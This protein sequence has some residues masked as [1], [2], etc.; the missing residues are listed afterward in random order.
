MIRSTLITSYVQF[1]I[2]P[3]TQTTLPFFGG[4]EGPD[5]FVPPLELWS[6]HQRNVPEPESSRGIGGRGKSK[7]APR[8]S[9]PTVLIE[10]PNGFKEQEQ[11]LSF[12]SGV[13]SESVSKSAQRAFGSPFRAY[14]SWR[15]AQPGFKWNWSYTTFGYSVYGQSWPK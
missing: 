3:L 6:Y 2:Q 1:K 8:S 7:W 15:R 14:I 5:S 9:W 12:G 10:S 4:L 13:R 11:D